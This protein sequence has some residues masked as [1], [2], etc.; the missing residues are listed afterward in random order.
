M[1]LK[2]TNECNPSMKFKDC[3]VTVEGT[4]VSSLFVIFTV[5]SDFLNVLNYLNMKLKN[6]SVKF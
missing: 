2:K 6:K 3:H 1:K 4:H 5:E